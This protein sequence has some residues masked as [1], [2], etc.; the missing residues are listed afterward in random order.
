LWSDL[1]DET[2]PEEE[3]KL[4]FSLTRTGN[5]TTEPPAEQVPSSGNGNQTSPTR[6]GRVKRFFSIRKSI[7]SRHEVSE[8]SID[9]RDHPIPICRNPSVEKWTLNDLLD[10]WTMRSPGQFLSHSLRPRSLV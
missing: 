4:D 5:T 3:I 10:R 7:D 6:V 8:F 9:D 1:F 2:M